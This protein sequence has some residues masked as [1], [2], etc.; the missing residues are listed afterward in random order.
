M[1]DSK[2]EQVASKQ[3]QGL[4]ITN[5]WSASTNTYKCAVTTTSDNADGN[6]GMGN[7]HGGAGASNNEGAVN[8]WQWWVTTTT[9]G[10]SVQVQVCRHG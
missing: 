2:Q 4:G 9:K 10:V 5:A 8:K 7:S 3:A 6:K 1:R